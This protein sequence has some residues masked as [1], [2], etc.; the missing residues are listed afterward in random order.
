VLAN[1]LAT[2]V[3]SAFVMPAGMVALIVMPFGF[4]APVWRLMGNGIDWM[5]AV[6]LW[7][8]GLPG[9]VGCIP[10]F[11]TGPLIVCTAGLVLRPLRFAGAA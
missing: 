11:G 2:P 8:A 4:D 3:I 1:L 9:A 6:A 5:N 7:V 10:A